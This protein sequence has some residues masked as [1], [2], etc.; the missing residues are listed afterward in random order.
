MIHYIL[1]KLFK[2][3]ETVS[4][5]DLCPVIDLL[6]IQF[7]NLSLVVYWIG[8]FLDGSKKKMSTALY[9]FKRF[10]ENAV[11]LTDSNIL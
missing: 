6:D 4:S 10:G 11:T 2:C 7:I 1:V 5:L 8:I 3:N 9:Q